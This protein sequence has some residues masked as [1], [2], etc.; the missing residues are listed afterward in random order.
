MSKRF[1]RNIRSIEN[2]EKQPK[3]TNEQNDLLSDD[4][5]VYIRNK[6][7][8][9]NLTNSVKSVNDKTID[10][11]GNVEIDTGAMTV[12]DEKPDK[13][14]NVTIDTGTMTVNEEKP[15]DKGNVEIDTGVMQVN[16]KDPDEQGNIEVDSGVKT[17]ANVAPDEN[18]NVNLK[19]KNIENI[20]SYVKHSELDEA[21]DKIES[22]NVDLSGYA[23]E[24]YVDQAI[25]GVEIPEAPDLSDYA[26]EN[27]VNE[28]VSGIDTGGEAPDLTDY[29]KKEDVENLDVG[30]KTINGRQPQEDGNIVPR[31]ADLR[32]G[33]KFQKDVEDL[34]QQFSDLEIPESPDLSDYATKQYVDES[35]ENIA[36][37]NLDSYATYD[38]V[39]NSI[40]QAVDDID[41][42][43]YPDLSDYAT[44]KSVNQKI[45]NIELPEQPDLSQY[46]TEQEIEELLKKSDIP[47]QKHGFIEPG[48]NFKNYYEDEDKVDKES[49]FLQYQIM[50]NLIHISGIV[51][52]P[53]E[54]N[55]DNAVYIG[56]VPEEIKI[57]SRGF[58]IIQASDLNIAS[59]QVLANTNPNK[60]QI[61]IERLRNGQGENINFSAGQ[62]IC[63]SLTAMIESD[64]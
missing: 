50:G 62:F 59:I 3:Y 36:S 31:I 56:K 52:N 13:N 54:L 61:A 28:K 18:G 51:T 20:T 39:D 45:D 26:T 25:D 10:E 17:V 58:N 4:K 2:I 42:P 27:Y 1:T 40:Q 5:H 60:N 41:I 16:G 64:N 14:G 48:E 7:K 46:P 38:E 32:N 30:V 37:P 15:N 34:K 55:K 8:Y 24:D 19:T 47:I 23:T 44:E 11:K 53:Q 9:E 33:K 63:V 22:G 35:V 57:I 21:L 12:N 49:T 6:D 29:A 43:D